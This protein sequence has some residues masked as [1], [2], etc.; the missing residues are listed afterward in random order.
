MEGPTADALRRAE[1]ALAKLSLAA[2]MVPSADWFL[3]GFIRKKALIT[4]QIEGTQATL[5][6]VLNFEAGEG[7]E[8]PDDVREVCNYIDAL[9]YALNELA[10]P[11]GLPLATRLLC[12]AHRRLM[13]GVR[14]ADKLPGEI[15]RSQSWIGGSRPGNARFVPPLPGSSRRRVIVAGEVDSLRRRRATACED[16]A[17][18]RSVRTDSP[19]S[20]RQRPHWAVT[21]RPAC[22]ALGFASNPP[23]FI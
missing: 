7:A 11:K 3:Y 1:A 15:R 21:N 23:C 14:G 5:Q 4:S 20:R 18:P 6:D 10:K 2:D 8:R 12:E 22:R 9:K 13:K 19:V 17:C 16:R